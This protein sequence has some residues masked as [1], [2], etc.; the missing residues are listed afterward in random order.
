[1]SGVSMRLD[2]NWSPVL[3]LI[4]QLGAAPDDMSEPFSEIGEMLVSSV[5]SNINQSISPNGLPLTPLAD[6]TK[7]DARGGDSAIPLLDHGNLR[8]SYTYHAD[9]KGVDAG[10]SAI[11]AALMHFGGPAGLNRAVTIPGRPVLG[12]SY[13]DKAEAIDIVASFIRQAVRP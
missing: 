13:D 12:M 8:D 5:I 9:A 11:Q 6:S 1:M 7:T 10:A 3:A 2:V 4:N